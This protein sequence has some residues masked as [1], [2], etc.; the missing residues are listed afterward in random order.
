MDQISVVIIDSDNSSRLSLK[1][2]LNS[3]DYIK[4][5][6][7]FDNLITG[8]NYII[9]EKPAIVFIDICDDTNQALQAIEKI[10]ISHRSIMIFVTSEDGGADLIIKTMRAGA[11]EFLLKPFQSKDL[12]LPL[13]KAK[14]IIN[15]EKNVGSFGKI[16]TVF[17]NKGGIGK[18]TIATN[19]AVV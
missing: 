16:F 1:A 12:K 9:Q 13:E 6:G 11:R 15:S 3:F 5:L 8:Y 18:T 7:E 4:V 19:L 14:N 17:S 10:S 2:C